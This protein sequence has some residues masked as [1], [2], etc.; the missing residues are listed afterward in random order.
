MTRTRLAGLSLALVLAMLASGLAAA[1]SLPDGTRLPVHWNHLGVADRFGSKWEALLTPAGVTTVTALVFF[2][3]PLLEPR[4]KALERSQGLY[5]T[6]WLGLLIV[7]AS[8]QVALLGS[9]LGWGVPILPLIL[10]SIGI[11][12]ALIGNQLGKS[13]RMFL[14]GIRTPWTLA[15]EEVWIA[16]H[17]L[18]GKL[19]TGGGLLLILAALLPLPAEARGASLIAVVLVSLVLPALYSYVLW[20]REQAAQPRG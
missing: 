9:A 2:F 8:A 7:M 1:L 6:G 14:T 5:L 3:L 17:R 13:R 16:T 4:G 19:M 10:G 15:S 20:R 11:L 18:A 12:F